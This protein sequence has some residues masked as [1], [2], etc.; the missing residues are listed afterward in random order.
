MDKDVAKRLLRERGIAVA[1][2][3]MVRSPNLSEQQIDD[4]VKRLGLPLFVKPANMGSSVGVRKV[5]TI[6]E[7]VPAISQALLFDTKVLIERAIVGDEIECA[8]LGNDDPQASIIGRI[9]PPNGFYSCA[10]KYLD[11]ASSILEIPAKIPSDVA[12]QVRAVAIQTFEALA[13]EG[14]ARVD[15]FATMEG[16]IIVNEINTIPGFTKMSMYP[17]L[18]EASGL[19]NTALITRL[20]DLALERFERRRNLQTSYTAN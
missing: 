10:S 13:C 3:E 8:V 16:D 9:I 4:M 19:T 18:W 14:M 17:K 20:I 15:M 5:S 2:F 6:E 7:L 1:D 11:E 12:E